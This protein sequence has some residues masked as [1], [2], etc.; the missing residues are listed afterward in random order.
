MSEHRA[1]ARR[2]EGTSAAASHARLFIALW[3][4][5]GVRAALQAA[6]TQWHWASGTAVVPA[7]RLH[8]TLHFLG[9]VPRGRIPEL[10][11]ALTWPFAPCELTLDRAALWRGGTA[12]LEASA[13]PAP[14]VVLQ[15]TLGAALHSLGLA[16]ETRR[17]RPHVT[18]ARR[19]TVQPP[20][21]TPIVWPLCGHVLVESRLRPRIAYEVIAGL[22]GGPAP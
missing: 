10:V 17:W 14:L 19:A 2:G 13:A 3:P 9:E 12:V 16:T 4:D 6:S 5:A 1:G 20:P 22:A 18:L 11:G 8:L 7:E 15:R 21:I